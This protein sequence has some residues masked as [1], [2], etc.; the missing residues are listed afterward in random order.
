MISP[1]LR[2]SVAVLSRYGRYKQYVQGTLLLSFLLCVNLCRF[3]ILYSRTEKCTFILFKT[4]LHFVYQSYHLHIIIRTY[5]D[6]LLRYKY[7]M[8]YE[9]YV[10]KRKELGEASVLRNHA[11]D[12]S[13]QIAVK[14]ISI[15]NHCN[16]C[17]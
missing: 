6:M 10:L 3:S 12:Y 2:V 15:Y 8:Y 11:F 14:F 9:T 5:K 13:H 4:A 7:F 16:I 17:D 1:H